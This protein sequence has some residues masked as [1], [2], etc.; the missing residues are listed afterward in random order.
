MVVTRQQKITKAVLSCGK[1]GG[2]TL[3]TQ[4]TVRWFPVLARA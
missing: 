1:G 4:A 3:L 2:D